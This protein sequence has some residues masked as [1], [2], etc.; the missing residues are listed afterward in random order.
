MK[1]IIKLVLVLFALLAGCQSDLQTKRLAEEHLKGQPSVTLIS[2]YLDLRYAENEGIGFSMFENLPSTVRRPA[3]SALQGLTALAVAGFLWISRRKKFFTL[4]PLILVL[5]GAVGNAWDR[6]R[7]G[8][9]I[10]FIHFHIQDSFSWPVFNIADVLI[11]VGVGLLILQSFTQKEDGLLAVG[12]RHRP[13][14][15]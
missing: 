1:S 9:V 12:H 14:A 6:V 2:G 4:L 15:G 11:A 8:Y 5:A 13:Q 10:D 7:Y 3:L